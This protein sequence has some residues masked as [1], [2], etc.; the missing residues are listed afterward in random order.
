[1]GD[2]H[3]KV[4]AVLLAFALASLG[5]AANEISKAGIT[6][7]GAGALCTLAAGLEGTAAKAGA[8]ARKALVRAR[9]IAQA[10]WHSQ[11]AAS[12]AA[13]EVNASARSAASVLEGMQL[14][15]RAERA[16]Q[17]A[18]ELA[19]LASETTARCGFLAGQI[20]QWIE[21]MAAMATQLDKSGQFCLGGQAT[22]S[23]QPVLASSNNGRERTYAANDA[24]AP[25]AACEKLFGTAET[26]KWGDETVGAWPELNNTVTVEN[27]G[28]LRSATASAT[29]CP[30]T[31]VVGANG[32]GG[33]YR[34]GVTWA[35]LWSITTISTASSIATKEET[36]QLDKIKA[37]VGELKD[38][39]AES[40]DRETNNTGEKSW[41]STCNWEGHG[42]CSA[43][44]EHDKLAASVRNRVREAHRRQEEEERAE[45]P[46]TKRSEQ[47]ARGNE[48]HE[49][50]PR[51]R[52]HDAT[53]Q[54][55]RA[56]KKENGA[57]SDPATRTALGLFCAAA[58]STK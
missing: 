2:V 41:K 15:Q 9:N 30:I 35:G 40:S 32:V 26:T 5:D 51:K 36:A 42:L 33:N 18:E 21:T 46:E 44:R 11:Q 34:H 55:V 22:G 13:A 20:K 38:L 3:A 48:A 23:G 37:L 25:P 57:P 14:G 8:E 10:A 19:A 50:A 28:T 24:V 43:G 52:G 58:L 49:T 45:G 7:A 54:Q 12:A 16:M 47:V 39:A 27:S 31:G 56:E 53:S 17:K 1:M 4:F 6:E 29:V